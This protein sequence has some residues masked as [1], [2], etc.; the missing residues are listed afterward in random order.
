MLWVPKAGALWLSALLLL[1][2]AS[3]SW[4]WTPEGSHSLR[5][6]SIVMSWLGLREPRIIV[7]GCID[8]TEF[9]RLDTNKEIVSL[10]P[11]VPLQEQEGLEYWEQQVHK[12]K[13]QEQQSARN[14]MMLVRF[15]NKSMDDFHTLQW[16]QGCDVGSDGRLLHW[17]DQLAFDGVDHPTLNKDL[18]FWTAW[19]STVAQISQPELEARLKDNCSELL[20][21]YPEKEKE[22]LLR[23]DPPRAHVTRH[24][25]PEGDVTLRCWALGFYPAD[26]TLTWQLNG[27]DLIQEMEFVETRPAGDGTFQKWA[28]V[29]VPLGKEQKYTCLVEHE[30]L[31]EP[32]TLRWEPTQDSTTTIILIILPTVSAIVLC[33]AAAVAIC[34]CLK[35]K[36]G[37]RGRHDTRKQDGDSPQDSCRIVVDD[38]E[39]EGPSWNTENYRTHLGFRS[40]TLGLLSLSF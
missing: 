34:I 40:G 13:T 24:P 32:L 15:Y 16:Q 25:R 37:E 1:L 2:N 4:T 18:R 23:S 39:I 33:V 22:R 30:G 17:Y 27:E 6:F 3:F 21:K 26:I 10:K 36:A 20:Q 31:S 14:L 7:S 28:S 9:V 5:Y 11:L 19:T 12:V 35:K 29:V 8:D 38:Q